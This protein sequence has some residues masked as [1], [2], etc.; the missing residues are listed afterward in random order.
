MNKILLGTALFF[1][2]A[3]ISCNN[4]DAPEVDK[5]IMPAETASPAAA[6]LV[7]DSG[8]SNQGV[9]QLP[10]TT[11]PALTSSPATAAGAVK[12]AG[13]S[14]PNPAHGQPGHRCDIAVG[15]PLNSAATI[16]SQ[17]KVQQTVSATPAS[18]VVTPAAPAASAISADPNAKLN[19]AHGQPGHDCSIAVGAPLKKN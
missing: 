9:T 14:A 12:T 10:A 1:S 6:T 8:L 7:A 13:S 3:L 5:T 15:A 4:S 17:P 11:Q 18:T 2:L 19:P 16:P